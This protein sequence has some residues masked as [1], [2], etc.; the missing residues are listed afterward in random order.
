MLC[1]IKDRNHINEC[2]DDAVK[3]AA[4][5]LATG[6]YIRFGEIITHEHNKNAR[7]GKSSK[8]A[9]ELAVRLKDA[10]GCGFL[11]NGG[12]FAI[13]LNKQVNA[14]VQNMKKEYE[15]YYGTAPDFYITRAENSGINKIIYK[16]DL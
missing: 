1:P 14:F 15:T 10:C 8:A 11:E 6:D 4:G 7:A 12:I 3:M 9:F 16:K 2:N 13:V 5:S